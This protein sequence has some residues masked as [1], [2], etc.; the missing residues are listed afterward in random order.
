MAFFEQF[1]TPPFLPEGKKKPAPAIAPIGKPLEIPGGGGAMPAPGLEPLATPPSP[2]SLALERARPA[3]GPEALSAAAPLGVSTLQRPSLQQQM[4]PNLPGRGGGMVPDN[5]YDTAKYDYTMRGAK[6]N[7]DGSLGGGSDRV[8]FKRSFKDIGT[9]ALLGLQRGGLPGAVGGALMGT[10]N[11]QLA[12]EQ[13]FD[14]LYGGRIQADQQRRAAAEAAEMK[15]KRDALG[16]EQDE[17]QTALIKA[18]TQRA[19]TGAQ[20]PEYVLR[21]GLFYNPNNPQDSFLAPQQPKQTT[22][23]LEAMVGPDGKAML[24]D[25]NDPAN[26]G[27]EMTPYQRPESL[28]GLYGQSDNEI[29]SQFNVTNIAADSVAGDPEGIKNYMPEGMYN[30]LKN[31]GKTGRMVPEYDANG[32]LTGNQVPEMADAETLEQAQAWK[33]RAEKDLLAEKTRGAKSDLENRKAEGRRNVAASRGGAKPQ[34]LG[35]QAAPAKPAAAQPLGRKGAVGA[36]FIKFV[37][38]KL[39]ISEQQAAE[40]IRQDGY[41]LQQ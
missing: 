38:G 41:N 1:A 6:R 9:S 22:P 10:L 11:P 3:P 31:G 27:K 21:D 20:K 7:P 24:V 16:L 37:A 25:V 26:I 36:N 12:R 39:G 23:K 13:N 30:I 8:E 40:K 4:V 5:A 18:N 17:A 29:E 33:V 35:Q 14:T 15:Q 32:K 2:T 34:G 19:L 28:S